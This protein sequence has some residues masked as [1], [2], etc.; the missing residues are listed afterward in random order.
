MILHGYSYLRLIGY[1]HQEINFFMPNYMNEAPDAISGLTGGATPWGAIASGVGGL[2]NLG[3]GIAQRHQG[4]KL[5]KQ[6][7]ESPQ[8][9]IPQAV[10]QNQQM[11][12]LGAN[13][14]LP[15]EQYAQA[16]KNIQRQQMMQLSRANDRR[17]G[18]LTLANGEQAANDALGSLDAR[19]AQARMAN[20][21]TLYGINNNV[22]QWQDKVWQNNVKEPWMRKYQYANSLLSGGNQNATTGAD[23]LGA[24][25]VSGLAGPQPYGGGYGNYGTQYGRRY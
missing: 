16:M 3:V 20:Q 15:S 5:L 9:N 13:V 19:N 7:G 21:K 14:G 11:A 23:Q 18:L 6:I 25:V 22:G 2:I 12:T 8:E 24:G 4:K 1:L 17:G 10:L